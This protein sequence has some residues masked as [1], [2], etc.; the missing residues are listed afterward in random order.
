[1]LR[2]LGTC[3]RSV[4]RE[5]QD[6]LLSHFIG[7]SFFFFFVSVPRD[8]LTSSIVRTNQP[9]RW[10][11]CSPEQFLLRFPSCGLMDRIGLFWCRPV[12]RTPQVLNRIRIRALKTDQTGSRSRCGSGPYLGKHPSNLFNI[13][14]YIFLLKFVCHWEITVSAAANVFIFNM[15]GDIDENIKQQVQRSNEFPDSEPN[16]GLGR[17]GR[18]RRKR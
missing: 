17:Q 16:L 15:V 10:A 14:P 13:C 8:K 3:F 2:G 11:D 6:S 4:S 7:Q 18:I 1:M 5:P 9:Y 12:L